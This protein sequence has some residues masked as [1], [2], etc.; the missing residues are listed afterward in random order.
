VQIL[1]Y[2]VGVV[3]GILPLVAELGVPPKPASLQLDG[4]P[5][6]AVSAE[7]PGCSVDFGPLPRIHLLELVRA[8][9]SGRVTERT[10]RWVN[11]PGADQA[12][13]QTQTTCPPGAA[14][15]TVLI[16]WAHP[17]RM[18]PSRIRA[19][20]DGQ[21]VTLSKERTLVV[22]AKALRGTLLT[23]ELTFPDD[24]RA[25]Y[26]G[27]VGGRT[28]GDE[29]V[30]LAPMLHE[31]T[32]DAGRLGEVVR[33]YAAA[34][35]GVRAIEPGDPG[36]WQLTFVAERSVLDT[37][38]TWFEEKR[39][40]LIGSKRILV[41]D[42]IAG[43]FGG[44]GN[45]VAVTGVVAGGTLQEFDLLQA[46]SP[47]LWVERLVAALRG[48]AKG[49]AR[50]SDAV[51]ATGFHAGAAP[52]RRAAVLL[53]GSDTTDSS[54]LPAAGV[55][56]YLDEVR[57]PFEA[58]NLASPDRPDWPGARRMAT[59]ADLYDALLALRRRISCQSIAWVEADFRT[60]SAAARTADPALMRMPDAPTPAVPAE[61]PSDDIT[62]RTL[63]KVRGKER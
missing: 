42:R 62:R 27:A 51:A 53:L 5:V 33:R 57:V 13:V 10:T 26:A 16:G 9:G 55:R 18:N 15:C 59:P 39:A 11:R 61:T 6:C 40:P 47:N 30:D 19:A 43:A 37:L 3:I 31:G 46:G 24:R 14:T 25:T 8:D 38:R 12:E 60:A 7:A 50:T 32:C 23:V 54:T 41:P 1:T 4:R 36:D 28:H 49:E 20:L 56:R 45:V 2:P 22:P 52:R 29:S 63:E 35:V 21:P 17:E 48:E 44:A 34:K 58:W